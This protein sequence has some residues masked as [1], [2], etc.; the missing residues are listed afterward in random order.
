MSRSLRS[1]T[2]NTCNWE[3][4]IHCLLYFLID[5]AIVNSFIMWNCNNDGQREQLSFRLALVRQLTVGREIKRR[6]RSHFL[7]KKKPG[8]SRVPEDVRL[9]EVGKHLPV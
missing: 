1:E 2:I 8:V 6:Y 9:R 3:A 5:L 7:T 4:L